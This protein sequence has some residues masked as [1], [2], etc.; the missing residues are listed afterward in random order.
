MWFGIARIYKNLLMPLA[1]WCDS[2]DAALMRH[3]SLPLLG[4]YWLICLPFTREASADIILA[5]YASPSATRH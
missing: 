3:E 2:L 5:Y 4:V 1:L